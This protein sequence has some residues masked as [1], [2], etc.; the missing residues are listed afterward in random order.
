MSFD[1]TYRILAFPAA[2]L[3]QAETFAGGYGAELSV[4]PLH[5]ERGTIV[6][7]VGHKDRE[8]SNE[9]RASGLMSSFSPIPLTDGRYAAGGYWSLAALA[10]IADF[11]VEEI[12]QA[13]FDALKMQGE[14]E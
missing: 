7:L 6:T 1:N 11:G 2:L 13:Q 9:L 12:T 5:P 4:S 8:G 3:Q 14:N 10:V